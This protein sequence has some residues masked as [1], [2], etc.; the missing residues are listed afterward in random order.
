L[1]IFHVSVVDVYLASVAMTH[2]TNTRNPTGKL[3]Y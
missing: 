1:N 2:Y 3:L